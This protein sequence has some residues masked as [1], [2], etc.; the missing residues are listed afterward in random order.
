ME[1]QADANLGLLLLQ[2]AVPRPGVESSMEDDFKFSRREN[3]LTKPN[4]ESPHVLWMTM[5]GTVQTGSRRV[6]A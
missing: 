1:L 3:F 4:P 5:L 2:A 6:G